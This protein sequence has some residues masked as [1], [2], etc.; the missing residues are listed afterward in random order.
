MTLGDVTANIVANTKGFTAGMNEAQGTL[1]RVGQK[2]GDLGRGMSTFGANMTKKVTLPIL[3]VGGAAF[4][5]G[6]DFNTAMTKLRTQIGLTEAEVNSMREAILQMAAET[7][8]KHRELAE[9]L[10]FVASA[11]FEGAEALDI[12]R[13]SAQLSALGMGDTKIVADLLTSAMA[14]YG[15]EVLDAGQAS[16]TLIAAVKAGKLEAPELSAALGSVLP[17]ASAM[18]VEFHEVAAAM[19]GMSRTGT[20]AAEAA[21]QINGIFNTL[22]STTPQAE[23]ALRKVGL[24]SDGLRTQ[25]SEEGLL[26]TL[27]TLKTTFEDNDEAITDVFG[28]IRALRG[29]LDLLGGNAEDNV[30]IFAALEGATGDL[31]EGFGIL[32]ETAEFE[33]KQALAGVEVAAQELAD[34]MAP[35]TTAAIETLNRK[36]GELIG[37]W[38]E[39]DDVTKDNIIRLG[40]LVAAIGPVVWFLGK[41][42]II[43]QAV[44][45]PILKFLIFTVGGV[46]L[47]VLAFAGALLYLGYILFKEIPDYLRAFVVIW[48][49]DFNMVLEWTK[50]FLRKLEKG[51]VDFSLNSFKIGVN[52]IRGIIN[53]LTS[54]APS[55]NGALNNIVNSAVEGVKGTLGIRSPSKVF[56]GI[57]GDMGR[58]LM[59]GLDGIRGSVEQSMQFLTEPNFNIDRSSSLQG[60]DVLN[61]AINLD[62]ANITSPEIA[63]E[64]AEQIGDAIIG[65]LRE[66]RRSYA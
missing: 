35:Y 62:G 59:E 37:W 51:F 1:D 47:A 61:I 34:T 20:G 32:S 5:I 22:L 29:V 8:I 58:G 46:K 64:Y 31:D 40:G 33:A 60:G 18:G 54:W 45:I 36:I 12:L 15:S 16:D 27:Q 25:L 63:G 4:K 6:M 14:A 3:A 55:L 49:H 17:M 57:G 26:A 53:G 23:E 10:F 9:G 11:G 50:G 2:V 7:G 42:A 43:T 48:R 44:L 38:R 41:L 52:I 56:E 13:R 30:E 66:G 28:N 39:Q 21:T 65:K 19:A 24:S